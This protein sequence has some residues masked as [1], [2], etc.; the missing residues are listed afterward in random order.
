MLLDCDDEVVQVILCGGESNLRGRDVDIVDHADG[1]NEGT[2]VRVPRA[3]VLKADGSDTTDADC[4]RITEALVTNKVIECKGVSAEDSDREGVSKS[5]DR[6]QASLRIDVVDV[7]AVGGL[8][9]PSGRRQIGGWDDTVREGAEAADAG[10]RERV[11]AG[12]ETTVRE[13]R[14]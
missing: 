12:L 14:A 4:D 7:V 1:G 11:D 3:V 5:I 2:C 13:D 6:G 8:G 10:H 9:R